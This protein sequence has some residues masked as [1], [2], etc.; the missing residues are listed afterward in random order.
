MTRPPAVAKRYSLFQRTVRVVQTSIRRADRWV[1]V[2]VPGL[3]NPPEMEE[4]LR[5]P[6]FVDL[7]EFTLADH[8][9]IFHE[10]WHEYKTS[11]AGPT[12]EELERSKDEVKRAVQAVR[13]QVSTTA[14]KNVSFIDKSLEGT[15]AHGNIHA[16]GEQGA[17]NVK[18]LADRVKHV[19]AGVDTDA[20]V[21]HAK[22]VVDDSRS[23][24][25]VATT[26]RK[27]V[28][29]LRLLAKEGRDAA[30]HL[31]K[32]DVESFKSS[33]QSW[34]ADKL[35]VGQ[36]VLMA[37]IEGY[38]EGKELEL[39]REDA[40]LITFA[41]QAAEDH[42]DIIENQLKKIMDQQREKRRQ[43]RE[44]AA[45]EAAGN[46]DATEERVGEDNGSTRAERKASSGFEDSVT[47]EEQRDKPV[48][49]E[50]EHPKQ[51]SRD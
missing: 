22:Q 9:R 13:G 40:L 34:F 5:K 17:E 44:E 48:T 39:E 15:K 20:V 49:T 27:N 7:W 42:K 1:A 37:F 19:A 28:D 35:L 16:L 31:D 41:K 30:L 45:A 43:E 11:F 12:D 46:T 38:R 32:K 18:F 25:D 51:R 8:R 3:P 4:K 24:D 33:A 10:V 36:S 14:S 47:T 6:R 21:T 50:E 26:L 29:E 23:K 2:R